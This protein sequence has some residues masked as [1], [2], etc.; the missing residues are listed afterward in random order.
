MRHEVHLQN[1]GPGSYQSANVRMG[2]SRLDFVV[3]FR[4]RR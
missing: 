3:R 4:L 1:P 2:I